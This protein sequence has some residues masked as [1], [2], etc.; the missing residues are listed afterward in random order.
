M[1]AFFPSASALQCAESQRAQ[2]LREAHETV[3]SWFGA[4][5]KE[6]EATEATEAAEAAEAAEKAQILSRKLLAASKRNS[7]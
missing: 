1:H 3:G 6:A 2:R 4:I 5:A 7:C